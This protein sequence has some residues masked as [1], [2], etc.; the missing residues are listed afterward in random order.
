MQKKHNNQKDLAR[1]PRSF[2][3][4]F[5]AHMSLLRQPR[6]FTMYLRRDLRQPRTFAPSLVVV[7]ASSQ[8]HSVSPPADELEAV[9]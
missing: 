7:P 6:I 4:T 1:R 2:A 8:H 9:T 5:V 3:V